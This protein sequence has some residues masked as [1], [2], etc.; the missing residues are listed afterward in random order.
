MARVSLKKR[1]ARGTRRLRDWSYRPAA[2]SAKRIAEPLTIAGR[3]EMVA[4]RNAWDQHIP[5][6]LAA[7]S[8]VR[9]MEI[10]VENLKNRIALLEANAS[11]QSNQ[12]V[13]N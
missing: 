11:L 1:L 5:Q 2:N 12:E 8:R 3:S 10:E 4:F 13:K 6:F 7:V 9:S